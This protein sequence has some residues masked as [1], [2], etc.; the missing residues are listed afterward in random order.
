MPDT[1]FKEIE[2]HVLGKLVLVPNHQATLEV[3]F[4]KNWESQKHF[5]RVVRAD[6][7]QCDSWF[8]LM[9]EWAAALQFNEDF[10]FDKI[11]FHQTLK[12]FKVGKYEKYIINMAGFGDIFSKND[13][14]LKEFIYSLQD[15][16]S[17]RKDIGMI[18]QIH[19]DA[20]ERYIK[21][22][23]NSDINLE[24]IYRYIK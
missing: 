22:L 8:S 10:K 17:A 19:P 12:T 21:R 7:H 20:Y 15:I 16:V 9:H 23:R 5:Y 13:D 3:Y 2:N 6:M 18:A 11:A 14:D 24:E 4:R 1:N